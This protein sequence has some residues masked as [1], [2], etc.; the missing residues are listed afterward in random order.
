MRVEVSAI[1]EYCPT[2]P[3]LGR[4]NWAGILKGGGRVAVGV[5]VEGR[6]PKVRVGGALGVL[7]EGKADALGVRVATPVAVEDTVTARTV[8]EPDRL[9]AGLPV[10][11]HGLLVCVELALGEDDTREVR[12]AVGLADGERVPTTVRVLVGAEVDDALVDE[13][14]ETAAERLAVGVTLS[15]EESLTEGVIDLVARGEAEDEALRD[16]DPEVEV[17]LLTVTD[18]EGLPED[19]FEVI[20]LLEGVERLDME[21][22]GLVE[23][24]KELR[25][26]LVTLRE[27]TEG[28]A[29][30]L[31]E[32]SDE[33]EE[34]GLDRDVRDTVVRA[35]KERVM[36]GLLVAPAR[37]P[38]AERVGL[39]TE[40]RGVPVTDA[41]FVD[42]RV[43]VPEGALVMVPPLTLRRLDPVAEAEPDS[44]KREVVL[45]GVEEGVLTGMVRVGVAPEDWQPVQEASPERD[46]ER[47][48]RVLPEEL[49]EPAPEAVLQAEVLAVLDP[50]VV[51]VALDDAVALTDTDS[52]T[53]TDTDAVVVLLC[54]LIVAFA[55]VLGLALA[56]LSD[57]AR[58][59]VEALAVNVLPPVAVAEEVAQIVTVGVLLV[60]A[61][62]ERDKVV[63]GEEDVDADEERV[64]DGDAEDDAFTVI[65]AQLADGDSE[66]VMV[67]VSER[68]A[69]D[70]EEGDTEVVASHLSEVSAI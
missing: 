12:E 33:G 58:A 13:Q 31:R 2:M 64:N 38:D 50:E 43:T 11:R 3:V 70:V 32:R 47:V 55:E 61:V 62:A 26:V 45:E 34:Q 66:G 5:A 59:E 9:A 57:E 24:V 60:P 44:E 8:A 46:V 41:V 16:P 52:V 10:A 54:L 20:T 69:V 21:G 37:E 48:A 4:L 49:R 27:R 6:L 51:P 68:D 17:V 15:R 1:S 25:E 42:V 18:L 67:C 23:N 65:V 14:R 56:V 35:L 36:R 22:E 7:P 40:G 28:V 39:D 30:E 53:V 63:Q 19:V 29:V